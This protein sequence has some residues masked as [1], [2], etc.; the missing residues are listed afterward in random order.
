MNSIIEAQAEYFDQQYFWNAAQMPV[1]KYWF[2][3]KRDL[4]REVWA[5]AQYNRINVRFQHDQR[6]NFWDY[7]VANDSTLE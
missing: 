4:Q 1:T 2:E 7:K 6:K 5:M 3:G